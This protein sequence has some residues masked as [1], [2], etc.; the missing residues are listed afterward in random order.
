MKSRSLSVLFLWSFTLFSAQTVSSDSIARKKIRAIKA[1]EVPKI[2]GVL[3]EDIWQQAATA[4]NFVE[5]RPNNGRAESDLFKSKVKI[6]YDDTGIYFGATLYD[7]EPAKIAKELTERDNIENDDIF[8]V[9][10]NGY[11]DHQQSLEFLLTPAGVQA[12]AK[13][14]TDFGE[15]FSWNAVWFSAVKI[16]DEG[17]VVEMK[18]PY[19]ELRFPKKN[20]Q[21]WGINMLRLVNRTSTMYDWNFVNNEKGSYMLYDG[22]LAGIENIN[23]PVRLSFLP[24]LSTYLNHYDGKTAANING[25][26][27]L[28]Y[29]IND[30]FTLDL[31]L[32]PDFGQT[33]FDRSVLNLSPFEVQFEEQRP[34][35]TEGTELFSKGDLFYSRRIGGSPSGTARLNNDE[36]FVE[37]PEK[38][39][40]FNAIKISGRTNAGL[41]IGFFNA[42]TEKTTATIRDINT[43]DIREEVTEPWANYNVFVLDQ[44]F[45]GNSSVSLVNTNV[46]RDG[47]FRDA[48]VTAML[49]DIRNRKN[50]YQYYGGTKGSFVMNDE[51]KFGNESSLGFN[52]VAGIHR[53]GAKYFVRTKDYDIGDLGYFDRTNFHSINTNYSYRY[54]QPKGGLNTL[55]YTLNLTHN[56]RLDDD[57]FTE[58]VIHNSIDMQTKNFFG[59]GGG[60]MIWPF[61][62]NDI[63]EPR[64]AGRFLQVPAMI[65][66]WI[67]INTDSR[68]KFRLNTYIDYYAFD[69]KGR[70]QL[71]Y[72]LNPSYKF[73]D[74][75]RLY[76]NASINYQQNDRGFAGKDAENIFMGTRNRLTFENGISSQYT[77]NN[78]MALNL[79]FRHYFSEV[80]YKNFS[81]L[82]NDGS[83]NDTTLFTENRNGTFNSWNVDV[84]YS[85]WFA[86]GSQLT[87]LYRNAVGNYL[88]QSRVGFSKNFER[89]FSEPMVNSL[90]V[91]LTYYIDYNQA[92]NWLKKG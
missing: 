29:G 36:E 51:T 25:G 79:S 33:S 80:T 38:V 90:S 69:E 4:E 62:E 75:L 32:I 18:I 30:A 24:Y 53:F 71:I 23:P 76:Y 66:P 44:R 81:T 1:T 28:K 92:K 45:R 41:G 59:F 14:T 3:D 8:G 22:V 64:T 46:T 55:Q 12:D 63:Y 87:L 2:D 11:N 52:K 60:L 17:W 77:F 43:G 89:L 13:I 74:R 15:D 10:I 67:F 86:P 27:D 34:F 6:L 19:S 85:W 56:R 7:H 61:G 26:M 88:E 70:Y 82:N 83:V 48:N 31:T 9:T 47:S 20:V 72:E 40:L 68:K 57:L 42:V 39:K 37:N 21:E 5:R 58:F 91:K 49:F 50:T 54:L 84:R 78:T 73:S 35:F 65:N 16:T